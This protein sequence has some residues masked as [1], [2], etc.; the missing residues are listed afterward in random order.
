MSMSDISTP[1]RLAPLLALTLLG[2]CAHTPAAPPPAQTR[3]PDRAAIAS[4]RPAT[5]QPAPGSENPSALRPDPDRPPAD[6]TRAD[7]N[8]SSAP[9]TAGD[10]DIRIIPAAPRGA[11]RACLRALDRRRIPHVSLGDVRGVRTP[12][13]I[14]GSIGG[15]RLLP[16]AGRPPLMDCELALALADAAPIFR[17]LRVTALSFSGAYDYR[18]RRDSSKLSAHAFGLAIDVHA[19]QTR[20]GSVDV[21]RDYARNPRRWRELEADSGGLTRC[22]GAPGRRAGRLLRTLA[23]RLKLDDHFRVVLTPDDNADHHDHLHIETFP[24]TPPRMRERL[25]RPARPART[26]A[27]IARREAARVS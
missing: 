9:P 27:R 1:A 26:P 13:V 19:L 24:F 10:P 23:C 20:T 2:A 3:A 5:A 11:D 18:T 8:R 21:E 16:R 12:V 22:I 17:K 15:L 6:R 4:T 25:A 7:E 14:S